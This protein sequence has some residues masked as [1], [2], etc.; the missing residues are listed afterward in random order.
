MAQIC[1][2][3]VSIWSGN[4]IYND[5]LSLKVNKSLK[6]L[7]SSTGTGGA[8]RLVMISVN[9]QNQKGRANRCWPDQKWHGKSRCGNIFVMWENLGQKSFRSCW[10]LLILW[11][12][13]FVF[14]FYSWK[15][16][17]V[18]VLDWLV[19][20][21]MNT[22]RKSNGCWRREKNMRTTSKQKGLGYHCMHT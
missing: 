5:Y 8:P 7:G 19:N 9:W 21:S 15:S 20:S 4:C 17:E 12:E 6:R 11:W 14:F 18:F 16:K 22:E 10:A 2:E 1:F 3:A 13:T